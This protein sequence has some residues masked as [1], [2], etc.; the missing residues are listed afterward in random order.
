MHVA[1]HARR[2]LWRHRMV[3]EIGAQLAAALA[4]VL[5]S[6]VGLSAIVDPGLCGYADQRIAAQMRRKSR[7]S[8]APRCGKRRK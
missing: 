4:G 2:F 6:L 1:D 5:R 7:A 8:G 3:T